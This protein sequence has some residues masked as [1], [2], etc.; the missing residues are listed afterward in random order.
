MKMDRIVYLI[1]G[2]IFGVIGPVFIF[3][4]SYQ[5]LKKGK[6]RSMYIYDYNVYSF[7]KNPTEAYWTLVANYTAA[8][9]SVIVGLGFILI[10]FHIIT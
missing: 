7:K 8:L 2:L 10:Y 1:L 4:F 5:Y 9:L 3:R 6:I